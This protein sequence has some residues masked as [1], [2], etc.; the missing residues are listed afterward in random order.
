MERHPEKEQAQTGLTHSKNGSWAVAVALKSE[1]IKNCTIEQV[2]EQLRYAM[3]L[4]GIRANNMPV[5]VEKQVLIN[6]IVSQ[7]GNHSID[8]IRLSFSV[9]FSGELGIDTRVFENFSCEYFG[10][11]FQAY[12]EWASQKINTFRPSELDTLPTGSTPI[13]WT[14]SWQRMISEDWAESAFF[15]FIP[16]CAIY[17]WLRRTNKITGSWEIMQRCREEEIARIDRKQYPTP[18]ERV[19]RERLKCI[20]W[21]KDQIAIELLL[22]NAKTIAVKQL[23]IKLKSEKNEG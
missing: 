1:L 12:R 19:N 14:D 15:D 18:E 21:Q 22:T 10:R 2:K 7:Y 8:E 16:W 9:A 4:T 23:L 13:D 5:E 3:L 11:I 17:D 20:H 6:W